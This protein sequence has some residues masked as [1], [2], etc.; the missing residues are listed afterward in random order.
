VSDGTLGRALEFMSKPKD[1]E[2]NRGGHWV[3][4]S[5]VGWRQEEGD[6]CRVMVRVTEQ[7][8]EKTA[9]ADLSDVRLPE[10]R[11]FPRT[12]S[13]P[14]LPRLPAARTEQVTR[15]GTGVAWG[16]E[17][18]PRDFAEPLTWR[19]PR[20]DSTGWTAPVSE[21]ADDVG[22]ETGR[23]REPAGSGHWGEPAGHGVRPSWWPSSG[24]LASTQVEVEPTRLMTLPAP[25]HWQ[26]AASRHGNFAAY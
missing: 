8:V 23:H 16:R 4:G 20:A 7:G 1:V 25:R 15:T 3:H 14:I 2:V 6:S 13:L 11:S 5:M 10:H 19:A 18:N 21:P 22:L 24:E 12:Q 26:A 9:W 17:Q